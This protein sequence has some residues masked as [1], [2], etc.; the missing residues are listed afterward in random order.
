[1][2]P[3]PHAIYTWLQLTNYIIR[4]LLRWLYVH[5]T[6]QFII[7]GPIIFTGWAL[8]YQLA[9]D[10]G[11]SGFKASVH[12]KIGL[13]L[14][15]LYIVQIILGPTIH[16][17]KMRSIFRGHRPPLNYLHV[18][19]GLSILALASY[20]VKKQKQKK[21]PICWVLLTVRIFYL[22]GPLWNV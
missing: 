22:L 5:W 3:R 6:I 20:Q 10:L 12:Q 2:P 7:A 13:S 18:V 11:V 16:W 19:I 8:G 17:V 21:T 14:L 4:P 15:I 9:G 1:M